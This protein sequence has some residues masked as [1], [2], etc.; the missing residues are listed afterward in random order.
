MAALKHA[1][2][3]CGTL[4]AIAGALTLTLAGAAQAQGYEQAIADALTNNPV[5]ESQI[6]AVR[7]ADETLPQ[8]QARFL[9]DITAQL[10]QTAVSSRQETELGSSDRDFDAPFSVT[11]QATQ[12]LFD[13]GRTF[14][15]I[16]AA[17]ASIRTE[18]AELVSAIQGVVADTSTAYFGVARD[19][20][21]VRLNQNNEEVL[22]QQLQAANDRFEVGE[23]TRTDVS[24][25]ESRLAR[26]IADT[27]D[28][29][30]S[31]DISRAAFARQVGYLPRDI[32][33]LPSVGLMLPT[34]L[35]ESIQ[36]A[37]GN[38]PDVIA[39]QFNEQAA[40]ASA[41]RTCRELNP[42]LDLSG[43]LNYTR[44]PA[45]FVEETDSAQVQVIL[46][47]PIL[48]SGGA[49]SASCREAREL[50]EQA[51][52]FLRDTQRAARQQAT[53][54]WENLIAAEA[55][56]ISREA[57]V[58]ASGIALD[59]VREEAIVGSRTTLDVLDAE[60][61]YLNAQVS[62]VSSRADVLT[63][64][65][66]LLQAVGELDPASVSVA[67]STYDPQPHYERSQFR[68]IGTGIE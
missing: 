22:E 58:D 38:N 53:Q 25:S 41:L 24:Q 30:R 23:V 65:I 59:G 57:Q 50:A 63:T 12:Q 42:S 31:L 45:N 17:E 13:F 43:S 21:I 62:L 32:L 52:E 1:S 3:R 47:V 15:E 6:R 18:R 61:E 35:D 14:A 56:V 19:Q 33:Q 10:S 37:E 2:R 64:S 34:S 54:A 60:Q 9:P 55:A 46:T 4:T 7:A 49:V 44:D 66:Q 20:E 16:D 29:Q 5:I 68:V 11:L 48:P 36:L 26:A 51:R 40:R 27:A 39:A 28:A 8:A 67:A